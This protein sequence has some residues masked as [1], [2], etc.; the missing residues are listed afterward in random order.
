V[1]ET[2]RRTSG[3][4][5]LAGDAEHLL[6]VV[7]AARP[8]DLFA[9]P[10]ADSFEGADGDVEGEVAVDRRP[11]LVIL[12]DGSVEPSVREQRGRLLAL[13]Q[14]RDVRAETVSTGAANEVARYAAL[15]ASGTYAAAYLGVG[16]DHLQGG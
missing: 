8:R 16:L 5:A 7:A 1:A 14:E 13:A 6:P 3:R 15:L 4:P 2:I 12:D 10:F 11:V 9:D